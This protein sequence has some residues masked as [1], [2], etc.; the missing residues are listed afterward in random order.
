MSIKLVKVQV[1]K[2][3]GHGCKAYVLFDGLDINAPQ[4]QGWSI[5]HMENAD[6]CPRCSEKAKEQQ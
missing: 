3:D 4:Y 1:V 5:N 2:C 6:L